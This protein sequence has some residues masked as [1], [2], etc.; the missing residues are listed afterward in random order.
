[1]LVLRKRLIAG[2]LAAAMALAGIACGSDDSS[3]SQPSTPQ[4][5]S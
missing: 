2:L 4:V 5:G 1:V 3:P